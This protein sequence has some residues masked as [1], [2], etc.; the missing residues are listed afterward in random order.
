MNTNPR[1]PTGDEHTTASEEHREE[2]AIR[3]SVCGLR[4]GRGLSRRQLADALALNPRTIGYIEN[5]EYRP[6]LE[7]AYRTANFFGLPLQ[8]FAPRNPLRSRRGGIG[9]HRYCC[10]RTPLSTV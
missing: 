6:S 9:V 2:I 10:N 3:N 7:L 5:Q 1:N 4:R 8:L